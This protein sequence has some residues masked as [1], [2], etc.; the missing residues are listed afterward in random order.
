MNENLNLKQVEAGIVFL[1]T[2]EFE[3]KAFKEACGLGVTYKTEDMQA[4]LAKFLEENPQFENNKVMSVISK[5]FPWAANE[6]LKQ[7]CNDAIK[8]RVVQKI[9]VVK[10][11][12]APIPDGPV[13]RTLEEVYDIIPKENRYE[14]LPEE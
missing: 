2:N 5:Q 6:V 12:K 1:T 11:K 8:D 3:L 10:E 4:F 14:Q 7:I 9:V 13:L